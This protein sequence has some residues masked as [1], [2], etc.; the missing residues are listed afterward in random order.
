MRRRHRQRATRLKHPARV[1]PQ[2]LRQSTGRRLDEQAAC[3]AVH[4]LDARHRQ[5]QFERFLFVRGWIQ[6]AIVKN[7]ELPNST[8]IQNKEGCHVVFGLNNT[9]QGR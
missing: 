7:T 6:Q 9:V 4:H 1:R 8:F 2:C 3:D 5:L